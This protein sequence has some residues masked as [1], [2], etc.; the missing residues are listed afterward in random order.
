MSS[1]YWINMH[2]L[3]YKVNSLINNK[4]FY[5][6]QDKPIL[7]KNNS[8]NI[9]GSDDIISEEELNMLSSFYC[10]NYNFRDNILYISTN[11]IKNLDLIGAE[12]VRLYM[13]GKLLG[14]MVS[15]LFPIKIMTSL[16]KEKRSYSERYKSYQIYDDVDIIACSSLLAVDSHHRGKGLGM[17]L[18]Q[19]SLQ[20]HFNNGG[21]T[22]YFINATSRCSNSI[23]LE[24]WYYPTN[25]EKLDAVNFNYPSRYKSKF[26]EKSQPFKYSKISEE[27]I[28]DVYKFFIES[29]KDKKFSLYPTSS[30]FTEWCKV[31]PSYYIYD[32][33]SIKGF[34]T[35]SYH[36]CGF[37]NHGNLKV[38]FLIFYIGEPSLLDTLINISRINCDVFYLYEVGDL[39]KNTLSNSFCQRT[40][41]MYINFYNT[42]IKLQQKDFYAPIL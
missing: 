18:I 27:N 4:S 9:K 23:P 33:D 8:Y 16:I 36:I 40:S 22:A 42:N 5:I 13:D 1:K 20:I 28:N 26:L 7:I 41:K 25:M 19:E 21:L 37:P 30:F 2:V 12:N 31:Y 11:Y 39:D 38:G 15:F 32:E 34:A 10:K 17:N 35:Y 14:C 29:V 3:K 24:T 6:S